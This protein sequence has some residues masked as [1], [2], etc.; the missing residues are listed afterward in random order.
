MLERPVFLQGLFRYQ[1]AGLDNPCPFASAVTYKVPEDKRAQLVYFRAG[2]PSDELVYVLFKRNSKAMRYFPVGA[3]A[4][5]HVELGHEPG[6]IKTER[7][8]PTGD[9]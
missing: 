7:F 6:R 2:N 4:A 8:G 5:S 9:A 3:R 1:G